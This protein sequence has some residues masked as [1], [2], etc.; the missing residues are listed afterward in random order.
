MI[1]D[2]YFK[3]TL[4]LRYS[5]GFSAKYPGLQVFLPKVRRKSNIAIITG[6][7]H[8]AAN[9]KLVLIADDIEFPNAPK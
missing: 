7:L 4:P 5:E 3:A 2:S 6:Q 1:Y 8:Q 9:G